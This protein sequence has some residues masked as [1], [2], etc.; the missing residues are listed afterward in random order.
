MEYPQ[1]LSESEMD[2]ET[3]LL[4]KILGQSPILSDSNCMGIDWDHFLNV[5]ESHRLSNTVYVDGR[6]IPFLPEKYKAALQEKYKASQFR[7]L[8]YLA[9]LHRVTALFEGNSI[10]SIAL[11]GPTLGQAYYASPTLRESKDL[12][13][14]VKP[15]D[16]QK[17]LELLIR[18]G[19]VLIDTPGV[20]TKQQQVYTKYFHHCGLYHPTRLTQVELHWRL[21]FSKS[22]HAGEVRDIWKNREYQKVGSVPVPVLSAKDTFVYLCVHGGG[23]SHQWRRLFWAQDIAHMIRKEGGE[24]VE[25]C[26]QLSVQQGA[27]R[28]VLEACLIA[29][30]IFRVELPERIHRAI[31]DDPQVA[32]LV[33][34]AFQALN[35]VTRSDLSQRPSWSNLRAGF[36]T[37]QRIYLL[38]GTRASFL[39]FKRLFIH[40][41]GWQMFSFS[42]RFFTLN[43]LLSP[44]LRVYSVFASP[45]N[46]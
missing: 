12:D 38:G 41:E 36:Q 22:D 37:V 28:Y 16:C 42:D 33:R 25:E 40:P 35:N 30:L 26:Y 9:E 34:I 4:C 46:H 8:G 5:L 43:Y 15:S 2:S 45:K 7:M 13:I 11:K 19:Y 27:G 29:H 32:T 14:L 17:A 24:F 6:V 1:L 10:S 21:Y 44:F 18:E 3:Q 23:Y 20:S 31:T 39:V